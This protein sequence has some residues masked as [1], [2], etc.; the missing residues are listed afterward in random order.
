MLE[1]VEKLDTLHKGDF[2]RHQTKWFGDSAV[3][4]MNTPKQ[5][6][7]LTADI[8]SGI[9]PAAHVRLRNVISI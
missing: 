1:R 9:A 6:C 8:F 7:L 2:V 5:K 4:L 3:P